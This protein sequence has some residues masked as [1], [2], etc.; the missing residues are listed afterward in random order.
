[1]FNS[2]FNQCQEEKASLEKAVN[3]AEVLVA[4]QKF[5]ID[6]RE[7][8]MQAQKKIEDKDKELLKTANDNIADLTS[9]NKKLTRKTGFMGGVIVVLG[10]LATVLALK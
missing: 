2:Y 4:Q 10:T 5:E 6:A 9:Q 1:M 3:K 8:E 7:Q